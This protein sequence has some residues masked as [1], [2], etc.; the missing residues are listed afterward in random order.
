MRSSQTCP[1]CSGQKF[2][3]TREFRQ[4]PRSNSNATF[5]FPAITLEIKALDDRI[6]TGRF[7][8]WLCMGCGYT[9][10]YAYGLE[11]VEQLAQQY[12]DQLRIVDARPPEQGPY[13]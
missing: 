9:E 7:E 12:P 10:F 6:I 2:A 8:A 11:G 5:Q 1:K 3:V 4:A 13:R